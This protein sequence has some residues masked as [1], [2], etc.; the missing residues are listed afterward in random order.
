MAKTGPAPIPTHLKLVRGTARKDRINKNEP[1]PKKV[2]PKCPT[3][4]NAD[5][6]K[7]WKRT[8]EQLKDMG[9]LFE[10]DQDLLAAYAIAVDN[11]IKAT[12]LVDTEGLLVEGRRDGQ[13]TNPAVRVQRDAAQLMRQLAAEFG[14]TPSSRT[15]ISS[16][17][18]K[19]DG[20]IDDLLG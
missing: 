19:S 17:G 18:G 20:G 16:E 7:I 11:Y 14:L 13:V 15:R 10:S 2:I 8:A 3:W 9:V 12:R 6:K 5:A 4:L 1:T